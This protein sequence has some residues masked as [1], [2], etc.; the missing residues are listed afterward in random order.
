LE[1]A[2]E[3]EDPGGGGN[4]RLIFLVDGK[5]FTLEPNAYDLM[6]PLAE[7]VLL[8]A[9]LPKWNPSLLDGLLEAERGVGVVGGDTVGDVEED[10]SSEDLL[11]L[12]PR[13]NL[14]SLGPGDG[15]SLLLS[16]PLSAPLGLLP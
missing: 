6:L 7:A 1:E 15:L 14:V 4:S 5:R 13:L 11:P 12:S 9:A 8:A 3:E 16:L 2:E 10:S